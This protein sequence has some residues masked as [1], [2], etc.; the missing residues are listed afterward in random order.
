MLHSFLSAK[1]ETIDIFADALPRDLQKEL[2]SY[3]FEKQAG[4]SSTDVEGL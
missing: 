2:L 1:A 3:N 4:K